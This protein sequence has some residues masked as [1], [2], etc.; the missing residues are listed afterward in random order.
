MELN[1]VED[2]EDVDSD[3]DFDESYSGRRRKRKYASRK[4][5]GG[6]ETTPAKRGRRG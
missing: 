2:F 1:H 4:S 6:I 3:L 5:A